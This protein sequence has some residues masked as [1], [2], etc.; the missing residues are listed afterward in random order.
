MAEEL[1]DDGQGRAALDLTQRPPVAE[2][3]RVDALLDAG[4]HREPLAERAHIGISQRLALQ[5]TEERGAG[6]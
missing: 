1:L 4:L 6:S 2:A 5:R 3:M